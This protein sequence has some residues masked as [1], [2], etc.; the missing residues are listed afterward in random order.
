MSKIRTRLFSGLIFL[1]FIVFVAL[2][3]FLD[4]MFHV[5][6]E[7]KLTERMEKE[8][9]F[10]L[11]SM[12]GDDLKAKQ[13]KEILNQAKQHF[14][15][16]AS[17]VDLKGNI[18]HTTGQAEQKAII[19]NTL[20]NERLQTKGVVID[21]EKDALFHYAVPIL[22]QQNEPAG[23]LFLHAS[24]EPLNEIDGQLWLALAFCLGSAIIIIVFFGY[25][26][27]MKYVKPIDY[28][29]KVA[30]QLER[31]NYDTNNYEELM[32]E[33]SELNTSMK[34]LAG[35]LQEMTS[36]GE[37]QRDRLQTV[38]ENIGAGII[39]I[40]K[41]GYIHLVNRTFR[42]QFKVQKHIYMHKLYHE[43]FTHEEIIELIDEIFMTET[44]VRKFLRLAVDIERR[45]FQVDGVPILST[46]DEWKGIVLV[47]HDV[48]ET[49]QLE[50]MRKDF[51]ANVSHELK[52]P[53]T[54]IKG[55]SETLLDG[56]IDDKE[57]LTE[58]LSIILKESVRLETLIQD[59]LDLSKIEQQQFKLNIQEANAT[60]II[61]EIQVLLSQKA[62][63]KGIQLHVRVPKEPVYVMADPLRLKQIFL[64]L[65]NNA[66]TYTPEGG[67]VTITARP[68][69]GAYEFDVADTGIGMK[70][71]EI[72]RIFERFYRI[73]KDR[74][75]N[76]GG[77]GLGLAIVKHLVEAHEGTIS[78]RSKQGK[79]TTFTVS[80]K[81]T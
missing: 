33:T 35:S 36:A 9:S 20:N 8:S 61:Q 22:K 58:F 42:K 19:Q 2:G 66:L 10:L 55:F 27:S 74:S 21:D 73:D 65:V 47:F 44:K 18:I 17:I 52:T 62:T 7:T 64:N 79:G 15:M 59:L 75:R 29:T 26:M 60:E 41:M 77:T 49:K 67:S 12:N 76:S 63:E 45:Y 30:K 4:H 14:D 71:S 56:A 70:K 48:T 31:G 37:M 3:L 46:D 57:A 68:R 43:A 72:P 13:N 40:D 69:K 54:S 5:F 78:V 28:A 23:Y 34:R 38:I 53:I 39:L 80:L 1:L 51:V 25:R 11:S 6:Y 24:Y 32:I 50:Q 81:S 16:N